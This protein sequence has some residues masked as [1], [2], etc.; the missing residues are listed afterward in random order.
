MKI[1]SVS[2]DRYLS[3]WGPISKKRF[4]KNQRFEKL[5]SPKPALDADETR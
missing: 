1:L 4:E 3:L 5:Q 2:E